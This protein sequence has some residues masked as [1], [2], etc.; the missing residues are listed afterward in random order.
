VQGVPS[1]DGVHNRFGIPVGDM[2]VLG[3]RGSSGVAIGA[4]GAA[5]ASGHPERLTGS[6]DSR[7]RRGHSRSAGRVAGR[8]VRHGLEGLDEAV[9]PDWERWNFDVLTGRHA[10]E[11]ITPH[12]YLRLP[13][14]RAAALTPVRDR[15]GIGSAARR[16]GD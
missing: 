7:Q 5:D 13:L 8:R 3:L 14:S 15:K 11:R 12:V 2:P 16:S 1:C 9:H 4:R 10:P 6:V